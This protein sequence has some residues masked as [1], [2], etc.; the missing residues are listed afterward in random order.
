MYK[1]SKKC[2]LLLV[3][4]S[5]F[6]SNQSEKKSNIALQP[7]CVNL[8]VSVETQ[9]AGISSALQR[10]SVPSAWWFI[11]ALG[12]YSIVTQA[13]QG[14]MCVFKCR[15]LCKCAW[16]RL[17]GRWLRECCR[18]SCVAKNVAVRVRCRQA[19]QCCCRAATADSHERWIRSN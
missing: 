17:A 3:F 10:L 13:S 11:I 16:L 12:G 4:L 18:M 7:P 14:I 9:K 1:R 5:W 6:N 19:N 15:G 8:W 2:G